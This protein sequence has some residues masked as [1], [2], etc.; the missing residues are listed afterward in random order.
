MI[1]CE[2]RGGRERNKILKDAKSAKKV[3]T[4]QY[5]FSTLSLSLNPDFLLIESKWRQFIVNHCNCGLI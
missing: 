4:L 3:L 1:G 5:Y 2:Y